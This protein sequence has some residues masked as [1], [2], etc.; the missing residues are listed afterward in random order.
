MIEFDLKKKNVRKLDLVISLLNEVE[1]DDW[2][3]GLSVENNDLVE[4]KMKVEKVKNLIE[5]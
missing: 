5:K 2:L 3:I 4:I 1:N